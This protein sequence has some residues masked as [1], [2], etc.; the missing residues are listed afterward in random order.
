[1]IHYYQGIRF[2]EPLRLLDCELL[3]ERGDGLLGHLQAL[4]HL[5]HQLKVILGAIPEARSY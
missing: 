1:M 4:L 3:Q 5:L 2:L